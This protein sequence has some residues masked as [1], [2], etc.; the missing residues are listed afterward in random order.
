MRLT[1][2]RKEALNELK[3]LF[4]EL[5]NYVDIVLVEGLRDVESVKALGCIAD[6]EVLSHTGVNDFDMADE[7]AAKYRRVLVLTDFDEEGLNLNK[8]FTAILEHK[9]IHVDAGLRR[10]IGRLMAKIG[11]YAIEAV[12][13]IADESI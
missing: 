3:Q 12:D 10:R 6:L 5:H 11:V 2:Q 4:C 8:R 9:E 7:L 13:N 1:H